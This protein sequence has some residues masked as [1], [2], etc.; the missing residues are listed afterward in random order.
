[1][2]K[3]LSCCLVWAFLIYGSPAAAATF[4]YSLQR[5]KE[6]MRAHPPQIDVVYSFGS[7]QLDNSKDAN[8]IREVFKQLYPN[9][10]VK[11]INGLTVMSPHAVVENSITTE[12][13]GDRLC[14]YPQRVTINT[15][16]KPTVYISKELTDNP[17]RFMLTVRHEQ[18]HLDIGH[19]SLQIFA[20]RLKNEFPKIV[21]SIGPRLRSRGDAVI[22][23]D[24]VAKEINE[25]Y[26]AQL[27]VLFND[28]VQKLLEENARID[29]DENYEAEKRYC[30]DN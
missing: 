14:Y 7:L 20:R 25:E 8:G 12:L 23:V 24:A 18:T 5:C 2:K 1:M 19:L 10:E 16:Y 28:F 17:C 30:P 4:G 29:T 3:I 15:G 21:E 13:V 27:K 11:K 9:Q 26:L 22:D 6:I